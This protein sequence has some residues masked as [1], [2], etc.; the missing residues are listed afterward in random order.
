MWFLYQGSEQPGARCRFGCCGRLTCS[1][2]SRRG[3]C[4]PAESHGIQQNGHRRCSAH[5]GGCDP[6]LP[7]V[8]AAHR[9]GLLPRS[10]HLSNI[11]ALADT[12]AAA[13]EPTEEKCRGAPFGG[14]DSEST[15]RPLTPCAGSVCYSFLGHHGC[16]VDHWYCT[17]SLLFGY[18]FPCEITNPKRV[19]LSYHGYW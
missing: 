2:W 16:L 4:G 11:E 1:R 12:A 8:A 15:P 19:P 3:R 5:A 6:R 9:S 18:G 14:R 17:L 10:G 13:S 7:D